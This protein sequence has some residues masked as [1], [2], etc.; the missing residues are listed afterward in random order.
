MK[1]LK[2]ILAPVVFVSFL[3]L[4]FILQVSEICLAKTPQAKKTPA[5]TVFKEIEEGITEG[6]VEKFSGY[7]SEQTY[8]SL[9]NGTSG[10]YSSNQAYYVLHDYFKINR[11][12]SFKFVYIYEEGESP[13][14]T[15]VYSHEF[16]GRKS[17]AQVFISLKYHS[18]NWKITQITFN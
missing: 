11:V 6:N 8:L 18:N 16:R 13:Y 2:N 4:F 12:S 1:I 14:A 5:K 10:Y 9:S 17:S 15:G 3:N 7:F